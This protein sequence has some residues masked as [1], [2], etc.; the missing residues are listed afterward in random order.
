MSSQLRIIDGA[1]IRRLAPPEKLIGWM[2]EAMI[3]VSRREVELPLRRALVLPG[4]MGA[5]GMMPGYVGAEVNSAGVKLVSLVP[6]ARRKGSSHLGLMVLYDADGLVP[7]AI[8]CGGTVTAVRTSAATANATDL[9]ARKD[10][11][12]LAILGSGE[13]AAAH[14]DALRQVRSIDEVRI[15]GIDQDNAER[16]ARE[17]GGRACSSVD[18]ALDGA[19]IVCTV[20]AASEPILFGRQ[21]A[22]GMHVNL[23]G[24]SFP[25][26]READDE[27]V[28]RSRFFI[29]YLPSTM[30]QAGEFLH[31]R[32]AGLV[33]DDHIQ[34]EIG[35]VATG[36][37]AGRQ[38]DHEITVY[39]SLGVAA[40]DIVTARRIFELARDAD[41][42]T[43]ASV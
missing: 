1:T 22:P 23:V 27:V 4:D 39:K 16:L 19:D 35:A 2:R 28:T 32:E 34:G 40:Q 5:V 9:L 30:D 29:D 7:E 11:S 21:L 42:G 15:W 20:T 37:I 25:D 18:E 38:S 31:A 3:A 13:Q 14:I 8:L 17:K 36:E 10:A 41:L 26:K 24:S 33:G 6:P 43:L 12:K